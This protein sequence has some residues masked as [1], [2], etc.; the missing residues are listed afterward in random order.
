SLLIS[1][2]IIN[3]LIILGIGTHTQTTLQPKLVRTLDVMDVTTVVAN[4]LSLTWGNMYQCQMTKQTMGTPCLNW[5]KQAGTKM[6]RLQT[7]AAP[8]FRPVHYDNVGLDDFAMGTNAILAVISYTGYDMEDA[9]IINKYAYEHSEKGH[10]LDSNLTD[11]FVLPKFGFGF[12]MITVAVNMLA[13]L[14][15]IQPNRDRRKYLFPCILWNFYMLAAIAENI[16]EIAWFVIKMG[17]PFTVFA[18]T[19]IVAMP[20][21]KLNNSNK[22]TNAATTRTTPTNL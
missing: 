13:V 9:M 6:Y 19:N 21:N 2:T 22:A 5:P 20:Q 3:Y 14:T 8:L 18:I 7:P 10:N 11:P 17:I 16:L 12:R 1:S 4:G 15:F